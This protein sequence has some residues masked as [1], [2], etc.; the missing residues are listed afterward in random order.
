MAN[1]HYDSQLTAEEIEQVLEAISGIL[2]QANNGKVLAIS[3]G[4]LEA[5]SVQWG[6]EATLVSKNISANG[7]YNPAS[8][9]ADGYSSVHVAVPNSY[10]TSDEGKV[11]SNGALVAQTARASQITQNGTYD[12]TLNDEVTVNVSGG[13]SA[14]VRPLSVTQNGTYN[15]PSG[16]DGYAPVVV[17]VSGGGSN[18]LIKNVSIITASDVVTEFDACADVVKGSATGLQEAGTSIFTNK[19]RTANTSILFADL[20]VENTSG[21]IYAVIKA[22][23][24]YGDYGGIVFDYN[25]SSGTAP[26][27]YTRNNTWLTGAYGQDQSTG[28]SSTVFRVLALAVNG[29]SKT[30]RHFIGDQKIRD[31]VT[32]T[33]SGRYGSWG[34]GYSNTGAIQAANSFEVAYGAVVRG[35]ETDQEI[36]DNMARI[37]AV[38][39]SILGT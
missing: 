1:T 17:N 13:G 14:V 3:N 22:L 18:S 15:P 30:A 7:D 4:K 11:V 8:D 20:G 5:R 12:T 9:N 21:T 37:A 28:M 39:A 10:T 19:Y 29:T 6:S 36:L 24:S 32:F 16:V 27:F 31:N 35:V 25:W 33:N 34:G 26:M 2:T 23:T 38:Y